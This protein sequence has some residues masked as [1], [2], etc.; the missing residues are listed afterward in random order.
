MTTDKTEDL[1][2]SPEASPN[3]DT[4]SNMMGAGK[5]KNDGSK[6]GKTWAE[7]MMEL[8]ERLEKNEGSWDNR[9]D[10]MK[11]AIKDYMKDSPEKDKK[12]TEQEASSD[13]S[14]GVGDIDDLLNN[15]ELN[16]DAPNSDLNSDAP[17]QL[18]DLLSNPELNSD[19][20]S[21]SMTDLS[22]KPQASANSSDSLD[23]SQSADLGSQ[24]PMSMTS[25]PDSI[26]SPMDALNGAGGSSGSSFDSVASSANTSSGLSPDKA[27]EVVEANPELLL[28]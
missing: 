22:P 28:V 5:P 11:N 1:D 26:G 25:S 20:P 13:P 15:P 17:S 27:V 14:S 6:G 23:P 2:S 4:V 7:I 21:N 10:E 12:N 24:S 16:S 19:A 18:D 9:I 3:D 8:V